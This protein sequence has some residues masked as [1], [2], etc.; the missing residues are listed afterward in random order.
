MDAKIERY[1]CFLGTVEIGATNPILA[2]TIP[3]RFRPDQIS[4]RALIDIVAPWWMR[5]FLWLAI[6]G[7]VRKWDDDSEKLTF[8][9][10]FVY[11]LRRAMNRYITRKQVEALAGCNLVSLSIE[12]IEG[13]VG[14]IPLADLYYGLAPR[15]NL[16]QINSG[17]KIVAK[18]EGVSKC[19]FCVSVQGWIGRDL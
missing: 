15:L 1:T 18:F 8:A 5:Y 10:R 14:G 4:I 3:I 13:I 2:Q 6:P 16:P 19:R 7:I 12:S 9:F 17:G 11:P